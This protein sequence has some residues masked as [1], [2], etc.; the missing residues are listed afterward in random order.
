MMIRGTKDGAVI[1]FVLWGNKEIV[2]NT[3]I[4]TT[5]YGLKKWCTSKEW[6]CVN[7][8]RLGKIEIREDGVVEKI[9]WVTRES[10]LSQY[11]YLKIERG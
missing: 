9:Y 8:I 1:W 10:F 5:S 7:V 2:L 11:K 6:Q 3:N 4:Y